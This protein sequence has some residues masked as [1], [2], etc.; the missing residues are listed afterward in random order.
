MIIP[1]LRLTA[2]CALFLSIVACDGLP[3]PYEVVSAG[4]IQDIILRQSKRGRVV[5]INVWAT[6]CEP[7]RN[8]FPLL[9]RL[10]EEFRDKGLTIIALSADDPDSIESLVKPYIEQVGAKFP[11]IVKGYGDP[12]KFLRGLHTALSGALPETIIY[13]KDGIARVI[14]RG[15]QSYKEFREALGKVLR[16]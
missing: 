12:D 13:N 15:E 9:V 10:D 8:E 16:L 4:D 5:M 14:L 2:V 1:R 11:I 7:C 6:W 3:R